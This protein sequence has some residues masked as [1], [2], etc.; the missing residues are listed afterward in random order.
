[1]KRSGENGCHDAQNRR[2]F[3]IGDRCLA[4]QNEKPA[5]RAL[6]IL[7]IALR[8]WFATARVISFTFDSFSIVS[9]FDMRLRAPF[10]DARGP[11]RIVPQ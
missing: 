5:M 10:S 2:R 1:M 6:L 8:Y 7:V 3:A 9:S 11:S 4:H